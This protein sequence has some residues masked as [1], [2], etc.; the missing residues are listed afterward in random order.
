LEIKA[1]HG[2]LPQ[3]GLV[4]SFF[5]EVRTGSHC[6]PLR[7]S[8]HLALVRLGGEAR[9]RL[10]LC[11]SCGYGFGRTGF[12]RGL[13]MRFHYE[14]KRARRNV[15]IDVAPQPADA[16]SDLFDPRTS[17]NLGANLAPGRPNRGCLPVAREAPS[18]CCGVRM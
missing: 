17:A 14:C 18:H 5:L 15:R 8:R 16:S 7:I 4:Q 9:R 2:E 1:R 13:S 6:V 3:S 10:G 12:C 11:S